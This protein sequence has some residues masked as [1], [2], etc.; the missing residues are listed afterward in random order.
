[1]IRR[2]MMGIRLMLMTE[3]RFEDEAQEEHSSQKLAE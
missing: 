3:T 2:A 1:M